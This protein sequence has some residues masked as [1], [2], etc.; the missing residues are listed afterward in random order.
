MTTVPT[1]T[2]AP[3]S[4]RPAYQAPAPLPVAAI[5]PVKLLRKYQ[6]HLVAALVAG[7]ALGTVVHFAWLFVWPFWRVDVK[8]ECLNINPDIENPQDSGQSDDIALDRFMQTQ[9]K[10][11]NSVLVMQRVAEDPRLQQQAPTWCKY[12]MDKGGFNISEALVDLQDEVKARMLPGTRLIEMSMTYRDKNDVHAIMKLA[13]EAYLAVLRNQVTSGN[14]DQLEAVRRG[15]TDLDEQVKVLQGRRERLMSENS[16]TNFTR[17]QPQDSD[18]LRL[19]DQELIKLRLDLEAFSVR[20]QSLEADLK[21]GGAISYSPQ[22]RDE[23]ETE[24]LILSIK[25]QLNSLESAKQSLLQRYTREHRVIKEIDTQIA[26]VRASL[27]KE[28]EKLLSQRFESQVDGVRKAIE[29]MKAQENDLVEKKKT[30]EESLAKISKVQVLLDDF[31]SQIQQMIKSR[32]DLQLVSQKLRALENLDTNKRVR[33]VVDARIPDEVAFP[34]LKFMVPAGGILVLLGTLGILV[35]REL[36]DQRIKGP[37]DVALIPR[38]RVLGMIPD[39][40]EDPAGTLAAE[41]AYRDRDRGVVAESYRQLR[42]LV[43]KRI[44]QVGHRSILVVGG[45]PASGATSVVSNLASALGAGDKRV[46]IIDANLRRPSM[47]RVF[48]KNEA[49]GLADLLSGKG[50]LETTVQATDDE[51]VFVLSAGT[52]SARVFERLSTDRMTEIINEAKSKFDLVLV[53]SAPLVVAGDGSALAQR[54]DA[55]ILVVRAMAEKRG[56]V[57]RLRAD[58]ADSRSELLGI[59]VNG[60][61]SSAGGYL[62]GN[63]KATHEYQSK[64]G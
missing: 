63:L 26:G 59:L 23:V 1:S 62:K 5:D 25:Q 55:S 48:K 47:H 7:L 10:M 30:L 54:C 61:T 22:L 28:R 52:R 8:F 35:L 4:S 6:W 49:P 33:V 2:P 24:P 21:S 17:M 53:D 3:M 44:N 64:E 46:L 40:G 42:A 45:L 19:V 57:A 36:V 31:E 15:I 13:S 9:V 11:M 38:A 51:N 60:V 34:H 18:H 20:L 14:S 29:Q 12:Y 58:L 41:T 39:A 27:E 16:I 32:N 43:L 56:M 37:S 50:A